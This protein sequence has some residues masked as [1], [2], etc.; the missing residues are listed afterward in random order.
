MLPALWLFAERPTAET[1]VPAIT[2]SRPPATQIER[3]HRRANEASFFT[4]VGPPGADCATSDYFGLYS[5]CTAGAFGGADAAALVV[6]V[7]DAVAVA[8]SGS[9]GR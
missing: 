1:S 2:A 4:V 3:F 6:V 5:D 8:G 9:A 7:I